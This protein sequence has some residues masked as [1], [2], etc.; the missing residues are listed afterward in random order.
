[1]KR[2]VFIK[3]KSKHPGVVEKDG[4]L[5]VSVSSAPVD[6]KANEEMLELLSDYFEVA[7]SAIEIVGGH[8]SRQKTIEL[9]PWQKR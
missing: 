5:E 3:P 9:R 2:E 1:M 4:V 7:K 8:K 6:G